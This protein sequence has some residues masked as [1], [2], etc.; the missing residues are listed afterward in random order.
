MGPE[1]IGAIA[2]RAEVWRTMLSNRRADDL[3][4]KL[5]GFG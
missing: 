3:F 1:Q 4:G 2:I 5:R